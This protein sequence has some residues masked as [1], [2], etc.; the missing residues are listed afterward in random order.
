MPL[1]GRQPP[2]GRV[3]REMKQLSSQDAS[4]LYLDSQGAHLTLTVL[5][6][7]QQPRRPHAPL[8]YA[9]VLA[10]IRS[11]LPSLPLFRQKMV[12]PPMDVDYPYWVDDESFDLESHVRPFHGPTPKSREQLYEAVAELHAQPLDL[13]RPPWEMQL[14]E[15]LAAIPG[16]PKNAFALITRYHHSAVDGA[17]GNTLIQGLHDICPRDITAAPVGS[18]TETAKAPGTL[19]LLA[20]A[21]VNNVAASVRLAQS[22]GRAVPEIIR[23]SRE[24][25]SVSDSAVPKCRFN[26]SIGAARVFH[27]TGISLDEIKSVRKAVEAATVNDVILAICAGGLRS[28]MQEQNELPEDSLVAMV[29]VNLRAG[30][31][32]APGNQVGMMFLPIYTDIASPLA[33]LR[34]VR[35]RTRRAKA[36][37]DNGTQ[38]RI[39]EFSSHIPA[40][41]VSSSGRV[42]TGL[43][44]ARRLIRLCNCTITNVPSPERTQYLGRARMVYTTGAGPILEGMGLIISLFTYAGKV[45]FTFTSCPEMLPEPD[46]LGQ[47]FQAAFEALRKAAL[48]RA[49]D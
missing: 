31:D 2:R 42:I 33:R 40:M 35:D 27:A 39:R 20:R 21:A 29:P 38:E 17:S 24:S 30:N 13:S 26:G 37:V 32:Q 23:S 49:E 19:S 41:T 12:R 10:H 15:R 46:R 28:W 22:F 8:T 6:V 4:F 45:D 25:E 34:A 36:Q 44:L 1:A 18:G 14:I 9:D 16:L 43:G 11:R 47:H 48:Q 7:Y 3:K 5:S